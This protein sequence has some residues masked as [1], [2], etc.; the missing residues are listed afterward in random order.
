MFLLGPFLING[1]SSDWELEGSSLSELVELEM[2]IF[3]SDKMTDVDSLLLA[4][5]R[6]YK[7]GGDSEKALLTLDRINSIRGGSLEI[8][9]T[10]ERI[11][12]Y[13]LLAEYRQ[14]QNLLL[15]TNFIEG[16]EKSDEITLIEALNLI[17]LK[18]L[19]EAREQLGLLFN[20]SSLVD[21]L[22]QAKPF[23]NP[24]TAFKLSF[25]LP[26]SGQIYAG[27]VTRGLMSLGVQSA[28]FYTGINGI[29]R[30]YFFTET[31]PAIAL[32]QGFYFGGA[33]YARELVVKRN[34]MIT[35]EL[36]GNVLEAIKKT[37]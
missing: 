14:V 11:I 26:G 13:Y 18:K 2:Q 29:K 8:S 1:Q 17:Q 22:L 15:Q 24:D 30:K 35:K 25:I 3:L 21:D 27:K 33:E 6:V 31:L 16:Y 32:F 4:K 5:S 28:L 36:S 12:N 20:D 34:E 10:D 23:R 19:N 37:Q 7:K 9:V